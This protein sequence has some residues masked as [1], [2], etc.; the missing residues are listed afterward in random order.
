M[1]S[2][3]EGIEGSVFLRQFLTKVA[4]LVVARFGKYLRVW[5]ISRSVWHRGVAFG[6]FGWLNIVVSACS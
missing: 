5:L 3:L 6:S 4:V 1:W 2:G